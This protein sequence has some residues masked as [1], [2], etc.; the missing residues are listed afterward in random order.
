MPN[1]KPEQTYPSDLTDAEWELIEPL[2]PVTTGKGR[3]RGR[4]RTLNMR[5][6]L[7]ALFSLDR[8]GCQWA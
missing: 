8:T 4:P 5:Q 7:N 3:G 2:I 6:V 1:L